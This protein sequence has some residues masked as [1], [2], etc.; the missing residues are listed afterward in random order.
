MRLGLCP[1]LGAF[2][3]SSRKFGRCHF[4]TTLAKL[5][6]HQ[7]LG[8]VQIPL[9]SFLGAGISL[10]PFYPRTCV[11]KFHRREIVFSARHT[12]SYPGPQTSRHAQSKEAHERQDLRG[13][14]SAILARSLHARRCAPLPGLDQSCRSA[15]SRLPSAIRVALTK[16]DVAR[17][18]RY[19]RFSSAVIGVLC[20]EQP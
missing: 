12:C 15:W 13:E 10:L 16:G 11:M 18:D 2:W 9:R 17:L 3:G 8:L 5:S 20:F 4:P 14:A 7:P 6:T 1:H 19:P